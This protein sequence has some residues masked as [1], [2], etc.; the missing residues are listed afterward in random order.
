MGS[1]LPSNEKERELFLRA[2]REYSENCEPPELT[3]DCPYSVQ[4]TPGVRGCGEECMDL[5]GKHRAPNPSEVVDLDGVISIHRSR[6]PRARRNSDKAT[7][8][9]DARE[10][11]L[12]DQGSDEPFSSWR[13][14]AVLYALI[15]EVKTPPP[16]DYDKAAERKGRIADLIAESERRGLSF[17]TQILPHLRRAVFGAVFAWLMSSQTQEDPSSA[18]S[19]AGAWLSFASSQFDFTTP[20]KDT[21]AGLGALFKMTR[22]WAMTA[23]TNEVI[24]WVP[25]V[26][27]LFEEEPDLVASIPDDDGIWIFDRFTNTYL[28]S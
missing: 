27:R 15:E 25:P 19:N 10:I 7:K 13:L 3:P 20:P 9:F 24:N 12:D 14:A 8:A 4:T 11:F 23:D 5:L 18:F 16:E 28:G 26:S 17:G 21:D 1:E 2:L 22:R 6:R